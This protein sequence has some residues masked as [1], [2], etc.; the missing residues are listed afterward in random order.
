MSQEWRRLRSRPFRAQD[1]HQGR[2]MSVARDRRSGSA[3]RLRRS[4]REELRRRRPRLACDISELSSLRSQ[5]ARIGR[6]VSEQSA[7]AERALP[8]ASSVIAEL[9]Q[10]HVRNRDPHVC[11]PVHHARSRGATQST[12]NDT[13]DAARPASRNRARPVRLQRRFRYIWCSTHSRGGPCTPRSPT[14]SASDR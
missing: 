13:S 11:I 8:S 2:A 7:H 12:V 14:T 6:H 9:Q 10:A 3:S 4:R 5:L 1:R